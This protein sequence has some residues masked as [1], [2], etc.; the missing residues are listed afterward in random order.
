MNFRFRHNHSHYHRL[1]VCCSV[2][3]CKITILEHYLQ[4]PRVC[5][6]SD[7][8]DGWRQTY[9]SPKTDVKLKIVNMRLSCKL[10]G[11]LF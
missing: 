2:Q 8:K 5:V 3:P 7:D 6:F 4:G 9:P 11:R 1:L 10:G